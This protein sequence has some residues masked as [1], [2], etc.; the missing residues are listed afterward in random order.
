MEVKT[1]KAIV[2]CGGADPNKEVYI[3]FKDNDAKGGEGNTEEFNILTWNFD[4]EGNIV[5]NCED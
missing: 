3:R 2:S 5:L 1:L 4:E